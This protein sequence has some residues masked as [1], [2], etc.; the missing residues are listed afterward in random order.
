MTQPP[1][2]ELES[3]LVW[4][5]GQLRRDPAAYAQI[6]ETE[7]K[8]FYKGTELVLRG[9]TR[10]DDIHIETHE[11]VSACNEAIELI[12]LF[13]FVWLPQLTRSQVFEKSRAPPTINTRYW[14]FFGREE[15]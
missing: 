4:E 9:K 3:G 1:H 5:V 15:L 10:R 13:G 8:P 11:G 12:P 7:R 14:A 6:L 2:N